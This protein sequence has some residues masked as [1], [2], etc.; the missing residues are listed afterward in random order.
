MGVSVEEGKVR[1]RIIGLAISVITLFVSTELFSL[2]WYFLRYGDLFY[3][4]DNPQPSIE[5]VETRQLPDERTEARGLTADRLH[6]FF[7]F[8]DYPEFG[9]NHK[10]FSPNDYPYVK[11][12][13]NEYIIA[14]FGGSVAGN[15][16]V[17]EDELEGAPRL[18]ENLKRHPFFEDKEI[19]ILPYCMGGYKQP[20]QLLIL[21]YYLTVGQEF[22]MVIN[23]DGFN[24][25]AL[26]LLN[27]EQ[28]IDIAMPSSGHMLPM[29]NLIDST[30][31]TSEK[32]ESLARINRYKARMGRMAQRMED[33]DLASAYFT[34]E[35]L[36]RISYGGY[37]NELLTFQQLESKPVGDSLI[38]LY[39][40][41]PMEGPVLFESIALEWANAS[42]LM[43]QVLKSR[44]IPYYHFLQPNQY[45]SSKTFGDEEASVAFNENP[46]Y[47]Y[48]I[49]AENG[50]PALIDKS[51]FLRHYGVS[52]YSA[53]GIFDEEPGALY[54]DDCCHFNRFGNELL[55]DFIAS[56]ILE[57]GDFAGDAA[58]PD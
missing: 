39:P 1:Q 56:S 44:G 22:D 31:L 20:Q 24:E 18:I 15:F 7:G 43:D 13:E 10:F 57:A 8:F 29:I 21:N 17:I 23:I 34:L 53:V 35:Q 40:M 45:F 48:R 38:Y 58:S 32:L 2:S 12:S 42:I 4:S 54:I 27:N 37:T 33:A 5:E 14:I 6:P 28:G 49:G 11:N 47:S 25:V 26:S 46:A 50:Y 55:A 51:E 16:S 41:E 19:V 30:T 9:N 3:T 52:F 36:Y